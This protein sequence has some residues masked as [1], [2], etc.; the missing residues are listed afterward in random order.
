MPCDSN[1]R[2]EGLRGNNNA[3][4]VVGGTM[5]QYRVRSLKLH[6]RLYIARKR[7]E[8]DATRKASEE[9]S[10]YRIIASRNDRQL[11]VQHWYQ[12]PKN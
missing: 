4:W 8:L 7:C 11:R 12:Y 3:W 2:G 10:Q 5:Y 9:T 6:P 1:S